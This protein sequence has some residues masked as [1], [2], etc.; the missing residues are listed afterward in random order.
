MEG[1]LIRNN[2]VISVVVNLFDELV[3]AL[4]QV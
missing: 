1:I 2:F 4:L 3:D